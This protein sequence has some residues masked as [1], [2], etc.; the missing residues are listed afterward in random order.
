MRQQSNL[1]TG[2]TNGMVPSLGAHT[3]QTPYAPPG[4]VAVQSL[5]GKY[6]NPVRDQGWHGD[7]ISTSRWN[8]DIRVST[9][10]AFYL[11]GRRCSPTRRHAEW[12]RR[13]VDWRRH[14]A[15]WVCHFT[16]AKTRTK[17]HASSNFDA[18]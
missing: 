1:W 12:R 13:A 11:T 8:A 9:N 3:T 4:T 15:L 17:D 18:Y 6:M 16:G 10:R 5:F 2:E 14:G 7:R